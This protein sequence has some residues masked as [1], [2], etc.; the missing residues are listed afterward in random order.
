MSN[1]EKPQTEAT[2]KARERSTIDFPY[3]DLDGAVEMAEAMHREAGYECTT[4]QLAGFMGMTGISGGFRLRLG[5]TRTFGLIETQRGGTVYLTELGSKIVDAAQR[6]AALV[7]AFLHVPLYE[8]IYERFKSK[9]LPP[10]KGLEREMEA[11]GVSSK[12]KD[13]ARQSFER[14]ARQAG[15]FW[16]GE[17]R[18]VMPVIRRGR[19]K[20]DEKP[21]V[22]LPTASVISSPRARNMHPF[23]EGLLESLPEPQSEWSTEDQAKWLQTAAGI[24]GLIYSGADGKID[25]SVSGSHGQAKSENES[26]VEP[27]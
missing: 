2:P 27:G 1:E 26:G 16:Q 18:L 5:T 7:E 6:D 24:F 15:F 19:S 12:Q 9:L 17:D 10:R 11:L 4:D 22:E 21:P 23:I 13:K 25:V 20:Q 14:S 3:S 8:A